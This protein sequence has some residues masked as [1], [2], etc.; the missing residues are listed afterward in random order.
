VLKVLAL[1]VLSLLLLTAYAL[2]QNIADDQANAPR[3]VKLVPPAPAGPVYIRCGALFDGKSDRLQQNVVISIEGERIKAI[4]AAPT[5]SA[6]QVI[7]LSDQT[8]LPGMVESHTHVFLQGDRKPGQYDAQLLKQSVAY[9]AI[10]ATTAAHAALDW[11]YT[12]IRDL[13]TEGA[14][15][16]DVDVR[17]AINRGLVWGPRMQ[18]VGR[19]MDVTGA[20]PLQ[21]AYAWDVTVPIG[22]Q[23]VDGVEGARKAVREQLSHGTDWVKVYADRGGHIQDGVNETTP[24][25][26]IDELRAIVDEAHREHH[27]V[28]AHAT[29][30]LGVHDAVEAGVDS[31]EHGNYI[32]P[33]DMK[34]IVAK[35]IWFVP[36]PYVA[37]YDSEW[38]AQREGTQPRESPGL[39][40]EEETFRRALQAN[41]KIAFGTDVGAFEWDMSPAR[42]LAT[43]VKWG[44]TS[45][46]A[47]QSTTVRGAELM[48]MQ[49]DIGTLEPGKLA[50]IIAVKGNPL[51]DI[52]VMQKIS[53]V[54]K[55]GVVF[56]K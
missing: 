7:D 16:A 15:Y 40:I 26:T 8:C 56:K 30:R 6:A 32:S 39:K 53:F 1:V 12:T 54:M 31:V 46:Q 29:G 5:N 25:F 43:M 50:D 36:T 9:R 27:R 2:S 10:E 33:E 18:V 20:Y 49:K 24:T 37:I 41:V 45:A 35:G 48:G 55:G 51:S 34:T 44:M 4:G 52:S 23:T 14:G 3:P 21:P 19:A 38:R 42:Q 11:G 22:V 28:A 17:D 47:L 13:E